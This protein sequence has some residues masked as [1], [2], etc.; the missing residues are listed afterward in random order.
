[1][2]FPSAPSSSGEISRGLC[3]PATRKPPH[4]P[5]SKEGL[6]HCSCLKSLLSKSS[7]YRGI[8]QPGS[9]SKLS[10]P[11]ESRIHV[12]EK[13]LH[14]MEPCITQLPRWQVGWKEGCCEAKGKKVLVRLP[15]GCSAG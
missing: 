8:S 2:F 14:Q 1:M 6:L 4:I 12:Q 10:S 13:L 15:Q 3:L 11:A 5:G 9:C 7:G